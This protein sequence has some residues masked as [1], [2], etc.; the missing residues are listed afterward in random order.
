M[1]EQDPNKILQETAETISA[2]KDA[3]N[4]LGA[5]IKTQLNKNLIDADNF[6]KQYARTVKSDA[7]RALNELGK[8]SERIIE[9]QYK[10]NKGQ[11]T[12][13]DISKQIQDVELKHLKIQAS[14]QR[15]ADNGLLGKREAKKLQDQI[16]AAYEESLFELER[17]KGD[18]I[19]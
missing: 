8:S 9:N 2:L 17:Q 6:T 11:L 18:F 5:V 1:A 3:F 7:S 14:I 13:K 12:S 4:S 19:I 15:A 16:T 10:L